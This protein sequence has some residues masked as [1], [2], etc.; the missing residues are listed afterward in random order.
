MILDQP[1]FLKLIGDLDPSIY[2]LLQVRS[3]IHAKKDDN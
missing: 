3:Y 2:L 1:T